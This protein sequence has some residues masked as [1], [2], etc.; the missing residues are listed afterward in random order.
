VDEGGQSWAQGG[1][2]GDWDGIASEN[3]SGDSYIISRDHVW[4]VGPDGQPQRDESGIEVP[5]GTREAII[6]S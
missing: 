5:I 6:G 4:R 2:Q 1:H 3:Y